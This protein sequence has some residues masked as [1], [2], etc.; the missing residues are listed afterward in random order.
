M[1]QPHRQLRHVHT[2]K[3]T[4]WVPFFVCRDSGGGR[5]ESSAPTPGS[6]GQERG[7]EGIASYEIARGACIR[8]DRVVRPYDRF[9]RTGAG[10]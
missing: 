2:K 8:A 9:G 7:D 1:A 3:G 4:Q 6:E 10:R 5:T